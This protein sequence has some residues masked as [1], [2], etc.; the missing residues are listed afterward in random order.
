MDD[1]DDDDGR[2]INT[3]HS[4]QTH[5]TNTAHPAI[6]FVRRHLGDG[7]VVSIL[8]CFATCPPRAFRY[9]RRGWGLSGRC[10]NDRH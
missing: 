2:P 4:S 7:V 3:A 8:K 10:R 1:M 9:E 6:S 5:L